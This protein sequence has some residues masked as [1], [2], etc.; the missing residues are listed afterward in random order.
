MLFSA[1]ALAKNAVTRT[2]LT[3]VG[4]TLPHALLDE[5]YSQT[6]MSPNEWLD[7]IAR[8]ERLAGVGG[9]PSG[10]MPKGRN[11][12]S[13]LFTVVRETLTTA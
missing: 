6:A 4:D 2:G 12:A 13:D 5:A 9:G 11:M 10:E 7:S 3:L 1:V 8:L